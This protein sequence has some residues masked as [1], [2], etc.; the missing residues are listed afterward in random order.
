MCVCAFAY[1]YVRA[2]INISWWC[3]MFCKNR[4]NVFCST[5]VDDDGKTLTDWWTV[6]AHNWTFGR[7]P[8]DDWLNRYFGWKIAVLK[9]IIYTLVRLA[10]ILGRRGS[11]VEFNSC[12]Y[13]NNYKLRNNRLNVQLIKQVY[14]MNELY[15]WNQ[16]VYAGSWDAMYKTIFST[17]SM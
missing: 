7:T 5:L 3:C 1:M 13:A 14:W 8:M 11:P 9:Y 2:K 15:S 12:N 6:R 10:N 16:S 17:N 4:T